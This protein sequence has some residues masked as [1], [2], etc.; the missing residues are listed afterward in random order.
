MSGSKTARGFENAKLDQG[1]DEARIDEGNG[2]VPHR[3]TAG[4]TA[5]LSA[6][7]DLGALGH[8]HEARNVGQPVARSPA[9]TF[10]FQSI[11]EEILIICRR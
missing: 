1:H 6:K 9:A 4:I 10:R 5:L 2:H 8:E 3:I 11:A 7:E